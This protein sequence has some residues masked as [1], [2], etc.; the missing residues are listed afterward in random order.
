DYDVLA[1]QEPYLNFRGL[2]ASTS[3]WCVIYP[4]VHGT[5][6]APH[7]RSILLVNKRLSTN[8]WNP[9]PV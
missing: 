2:S 6:S 3:H 4:T 1:I 5:D 8:T 7:T 9:V